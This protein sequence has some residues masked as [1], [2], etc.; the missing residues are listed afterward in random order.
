MK[1]HSIFKANAIFWGIAFVATGVAAILW[2]AGTIQGS[3]YLIL[4]TALMAAIFIRSLIGFHFVPLL[5]SAAHIVHLYRGMLGIPANLASWMIIIASLVIGIGL[6]LIFGGLKKSIKRKMRANYDYSSGPK[7][8]G[9]GD[10]SSENSGNIS[11]NTAYISGSNLHIENGFGEQTRYIR[12]EEF[13]SGHIENGFGQLT[14]YF[15]DVKFQDNSA[16]L[17]IENG[18]GHL[19]VYMPSTWLAVLTEENGMGQINVH[20]TPSTDT[21]APVINLHVENGMGKVDLFFT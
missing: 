17:N 14:V 2:A 5:V 16:S 1:K 12:G 4:M 8:I 10:G 21:D 6:E 19:N 7:T 15:E 11:V 9:S 13:C 3:I 20:G 18:F